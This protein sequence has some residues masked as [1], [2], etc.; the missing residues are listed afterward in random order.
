ML[1]LRLIIV[2]GGCYYLLALVLVSLLFV[3]PPPACR[4]EMFNV[5]DPRRCHGLLAGG[6]VLACL[7]LRPDGLTVMMPGYLSGALDGISRAVLA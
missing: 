7:L 3:P 4:K 1:G 2:G 6:G 5:A